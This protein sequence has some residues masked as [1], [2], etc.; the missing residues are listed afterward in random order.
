MAERRVVK[1]KRNATAKVSSDS[2]DRLKCGMVSGL[3]LWARVS[4][5]RLLRHSMHV[6]GMMWLCMTVW[7]IC[8]ILIAIARSLLLRLSQAKTVRLILFYD[9]WSWFRS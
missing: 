1:S 3:G 5:A 8:S 2:E 9:V 7:L 4:W 6:M